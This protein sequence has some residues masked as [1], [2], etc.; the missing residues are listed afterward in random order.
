MTFPIAI[1][2]KGFYPRDIPPL[3]FYVPINGTITVTSLIG[4]ISKS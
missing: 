2:T 3:A 4:S 1:A